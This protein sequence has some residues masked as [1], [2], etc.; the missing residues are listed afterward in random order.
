MT[1]LGLQDLIP[2]ISVKG[3]GIEVKLKY[4][5]QSI[6]QADISSYLFFYKNRFYQITFFGW[7]VSR[8]SCS[9]KEY[10]IIYLNII[11]ETDTFISFAF[12]QKDILY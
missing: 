5:T 6:G 12:I 10:H 8:Y 3:Q 2:A 4:L 7:F 9:T 11:I 1:H